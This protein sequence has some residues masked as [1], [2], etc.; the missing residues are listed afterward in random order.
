[1]SY[2]FRFVAI[3]ALFTTAL[4]TSN[5]IAVKLFALG[6]LVLPAA[7]ILFPVTYILGDVLTEVYG[8]ARTRKVIWLGFVC[9]LVAVAAIWAAGALPPAGFWGGQAAWDEI[10][11]FVPRILFASFAAYLVGEFANAYVLARMKIATAGR[12]LWARTIG[13]TIIGQGLDS[14]VFITIAFAGVLPTGALASTILLQWILKTA[15]EAAATPLT[16]AI[17]GSLKRAE[18][19]DPFDRDTRF[20]PLLLRD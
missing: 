5:L 7:V 9:N 19:A 12:H 4:I 18:G 13:S 17:V 16:Y 1:M 10:F 6:T 2:S 3:A 15:Y 8:Y 20:N 11:G 14:T